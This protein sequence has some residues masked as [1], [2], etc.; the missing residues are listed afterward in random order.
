MVYYLISEFS[1]TGMS[2][3]A[4]SSAVERAAGRVDGVEAAHVNLAAERLRVRSE[5][6]V[7]DAVI[8]AVKKAG[9]GALPSQGFKKQSMLDEER[10]AK[11]LR[12]KKNRLIVAIAFA[13]PPVLYIHGNDG[14]SAIPSCAGQSYALCGS[15]TVAAHPNRCGGL[16]FLCEG[17]RRSFQ[18]SSKYGFPHFCRNHCFAGIFHLFHVENLSGKRP[19]RP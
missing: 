6:D 4:C 2:C 19:C 16:G 1:I 18:T 5:V 11:E 9:F 3:A 10:R 12:G 14:W 17:D 15:S 7:S 8:N 13:I